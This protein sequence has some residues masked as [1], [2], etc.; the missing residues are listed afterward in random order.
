LLPA[1]RSP[2][3]LGALRHF[4]VFVEMISVGRCPFEL[5]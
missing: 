3:H 5:T 1:G 2:L 4:L